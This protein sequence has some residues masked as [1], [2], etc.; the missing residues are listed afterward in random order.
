[1]SKYYASLKENPN[2]Q[3][4]VTYIYKAAD[5]SLGNIAVFEYK[6]EQPSTTSFIRTNPKTV[7][8]IK[9]QL[10]TKK[11][12]EIYAAL[13]RD[14]SMTCARDFRVVKNV[15]YEQKR[16]EKT[17]RVNRLNIA[18]EIL[19]VLGMVND[20]PFVQSII[21]NK[22]QVP[23]VIC[24]T[25][26]QIIDLKH[27]V[28]NS[29]NQAIGIDRTFN[30][31]NYYVTTLVYK[32]Q[33]VVRKESTKTNKHDNQDLPAQPIFLGLVLLH[34]D[35]TYKTY[36][37]FLEHIKT[38]LESDIEAVELRLPE[39]I[40]FGTD[41]EKALT[42]AIDNVFPSS[43]R[44]L[45]TKH[46]KDNVKHYLQNR[47]GMEQPIRESVMDKIFG[48]DGITDANCTID[49]E[50]KSN[51]LKMSLE[52]KYSKFNS[53]FEKNLKTRLKE[54][55]FDPCR[56]DNGKRNWTNNN[57]ESLNNILKLAVDW[58]PQCT[59][60][61]I[62]KIHSVTELHF[63]DYRSALHD[64]GNYRLARKEYA[65]NVNDALWRCKSDDEK[66]ELFMNF[67]KDTKKRKRE[68][69]V[70]SN[71]GKFSVI[72]KAKTVARKANQHKR[73]RNERT[74]KR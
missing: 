12:K 52:E 14:D 49:F 51:E 33:R 15:K 38:E 22:D 68:A 11:P 71:D 9:T 5:E 48:T 40:E 7:D 56:Q 74:R 73:P 35:A 61:L 46:L 63:L 24:Y 67:L 26:E 27:F 31:G 64:S 32:N 57:A 20:H 54:Y 60:E 30:L 44:V 23:N 34:K 18:D 13:K 10:A 28:R 39:S 19:E 59:K 43:V 2:F 69:L 58:K 72:S 41:D 1:M 62:E 47:V 37:S 4:H 53:Y 17:E 66:E 29:N 8:K 25:N 21:H 3:K 50:S 6:G 36:K 45:C 16:K 65:Y 42:K 70:T 55:V